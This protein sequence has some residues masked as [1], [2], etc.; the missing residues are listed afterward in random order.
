[1][2]RH[3]RRTHLEEEEE[4][5]FVS[6]TDMTVSFLFIVMI[7]LAF[8]ASR[9][10]DQDTVPRSV[11]EEVRDER[12][13]LREETE[14][15]ETE[16]DQTRRERD[17]ALKELQRLR[18]LVSDLQ[19]R[20]E[21]AERDLAETREELERSRERIAELE[22]RVAEL[23]DEIARLEAELARLKR[24]DP[25]EAYLSQVAQERRRILELLRD[26]ILQDFPDL[27][28]VISSESDALRF[29]GEGLFA[30]G[31]RQLRA[32][33]R[34]VVERIAERLDT[35]LPCYTLGE[36]SDWDAECNSGFAIVEAVQ[37]EGHTD[38]VGGDL[39]NL[40]L[41]A[42]RAAA[43]Y[44]AMTAR[45]PGLLDHL[46]FNDQPVISVAGYGKN[47]P[48]EDNATVEGRATNRR[49]DLRFIMVS[50]SRSEEI[51]YIRERL[52]EVD[53]DGGQNGAE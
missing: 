8:F 23:E 16:L 21:T 53:T 30:S 47:R 48:V 24:P 32:D 4:S 46:N 11:Y 35:L 5:A 10:N 14:R 29:Q 1:M 45:V 13:V 19:V 44:A 33:K 26:Q 17:D 31:S 28:V 27:E 37:I 7:L 15:L 36:R 51:A 43:T 25:L 9:F 50:P 20:L 39:D 22:A 40:E 2:R 6:M 34:V 42:D 12:D 3:G 38:S 41:S 52:A 49:I 18:G